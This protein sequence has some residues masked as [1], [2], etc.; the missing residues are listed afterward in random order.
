MKA[1]KNVETFED[2]S[3]F[4]FLGMVKNGTIFAQELS[5]KCV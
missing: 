5:I 4:E 2:F 1:F 3:G